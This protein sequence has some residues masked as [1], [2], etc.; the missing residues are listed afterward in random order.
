MLDYKSMKGL[1]VCAAHFLLVTYSS[2]KLTQSVC[3]G[4]GNIRH[5]F[6]CDDFCHQSIPGRPFLSTGVI[7]AHAMLPTQ[8]SEDKNMKGSG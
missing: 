5:P 7:A 2:G 8:A 1:S 6:P 4:G 3:R